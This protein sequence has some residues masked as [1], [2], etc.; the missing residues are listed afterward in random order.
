MTHQPITTLA[1]LDAIDHDECV[2]GYLEARRG[3]AEP[4]GNHSRSYW[5]GWRMR[6]ADYGEIAAPPGHTEL[7]REAMRAGRLRL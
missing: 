1:E 4:G 7:V 3:D 6:M 5:H 2:R